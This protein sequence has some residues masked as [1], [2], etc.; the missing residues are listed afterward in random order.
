M[1]R[2]NA[3]LSRREENILLAV[4]KLDEEAYAIPILKYL[5]EVTGESVSI[6]GIYVP[7]DRLIRKGLLTS[8]QSEPLPERG[9]MSRRYYKLT[10]KGREELVEARKV[11]DRLWDG[12]QDLSLEAE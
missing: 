8:W 2:G 5:A 4:W 9:G 7:L 1:K 10:K 11:N 3:M 6:G 12:L